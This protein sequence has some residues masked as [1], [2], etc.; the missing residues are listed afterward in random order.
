MSIVKV[1]CVYSYAYTDKDDVMRIRQELRKIG[2]ENKIP[3]KTDKAT[4]QGQYQIKGNSRI[5]VY[6]E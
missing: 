2:I 1:I 6:Y 5:S 4:G 3:Y